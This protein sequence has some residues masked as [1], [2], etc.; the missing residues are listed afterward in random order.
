MNT[1]PSLRKFLVH[2]GQLDP[3]PAWLLIHPGASATMTAVD[4]E[5]R[6]IVEIA[7]PDL[8][9]AALSESPVGGIITTNRAAWVANLARLLSGFRADDRLVAVLTL[10]I[11]RAR[12]GSVIWNLGRRGPL[13][14]IEDQAPL[15]RQHFRECHLLG[16]AEEELLG[17]RWVLA[18]ADR[19]CAAVRADGA[20]LGSTPLGADF[21]KSLT[22]GHQHFY[23]GDKP[24]LPGALATKIGLAP[25]GQLKLGAT[26][27]ARF[28]TLTPSKVGWSRVVGI[29]FLCEPPPG[30]PLPLS[31]LSPVERDVFERITRGKTNRAIAEARGVS[32]ATVKVQVSEV[33]RKLGASRRSDLIIAQ[34]PHLQPMV[35]ASG[36]L[37]RSLGA[38]K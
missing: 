30:A 19:R 20:L 13:R 17:L 22:H 28:D 10:A 21:L 38:T 15:V 34:V 31:R 7:Q 32:P 9:F 37:P 25:S 2:L 3:A 14:S 29:E 36:I 24:T 5:R 6:Q 16:G 26:S 18:R 23:H 8:V 4:T 12:L 1:T 35:S 27:T 11:G 33:L